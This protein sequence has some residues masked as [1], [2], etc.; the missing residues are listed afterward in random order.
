ML[1]WFT[2]FV[3]HDPASLESLNPGR[4]L[5]FGQD[6]P[7]FAFR[8]TKFTSDKV[9][10][11]KQLPQAT[12]PQQPLFWRPKQRLGSLGD[13]DP[14]VR[15]LAEAMLDLDEMLRERRR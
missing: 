3:G 10:V 6:Q 13:D 9:A 11:R 7:V 15:S 4:Y 5:I 14:Q 12:Q 2:R 8:R 1:V